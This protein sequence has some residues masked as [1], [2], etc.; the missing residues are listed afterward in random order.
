[1]GRDGSGQKAALLVK[2][3]IWCCSPSRL[4]ARNGLKL[5]RI[6]RERTRVP[7]SGDRSRE[8]ADRVMGLNYGAGPGTD[9]VSSLQQCT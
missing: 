1:M 5:Q 7:S 6:C 8:E 4:P 9:Y 3:S 2:S